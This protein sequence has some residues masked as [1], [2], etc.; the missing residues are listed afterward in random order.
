[1][2]SELRYQ[3]SRKP[4]VVHPDGRQEID[5]TPTPLEA[6]EFWRAQYLQ[7]KG[8]DRKEKVAIFA[9]YF[10]V[11]VPLAERM[12]DGQVPHRQEEDEIL[13]FVVD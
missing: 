12:L 10:Q 7:A 9:K 13:V 8:R 3:C 4:P 5:L 2:S 11:E 1:M 6:Y